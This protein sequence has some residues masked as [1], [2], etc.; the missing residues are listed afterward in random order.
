MPPKSTGTA[1]FIVLG[2]LQCL[3]LAGC[4]SVSDQTLIDKTSQGAVYL[5][6]LSTRGTT[7]KYSGPLNAFHASQPILLP[8]H[9]IARVLIGLEITPL[10][11]AGIEQPIS[12]LSPVEV[13]FLAPLVSKALAQADK[14]QRVRFYLGAGGDGTAGM[15]FVD[16]PFLHF[17]LHRFRN[18]LHESGSGAALSFSPKAAERRGDVPQTW[19]TIEPERPAVTVD[20][21][22]LATLP[23]ASVMGNIPDETIPHDQARPTNDITGLKSDNAEE[24][25]SLRELVINQAKELQGLKEEMESLRRESGEQSHSSKKPRGRKSMPRSH[26]TTP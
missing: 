20:Y 26:G 12:L 9:T 15:L 19:M 4:G 23:G 11:T 13:G 16:K 6:R 8:S 5:E 14:D 2:A 25:R 10:Q 3:L 7:A 22:M 1:F 21:E 18:N 24:L 17:T